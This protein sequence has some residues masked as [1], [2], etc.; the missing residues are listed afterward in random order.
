MKRIIPL[1]ISF[2]F[3]IISV[4]AQSTITFK[5]ENVPVKDGRKVGIRG[6]IYPLSWDSSTPLKKEKDA[7]TVV[8]DFADTED[9]LQFKFV[10]YTSDDD[11][12]WEGIQ[13]RT[14]DLSKNENSV[15]QNIWNKEQIIDISTLKPISSELL[16]KDYELIEKMVLDV[17]PGTFRYNDKD[18]I[19]LVL[20]ELKTKFSQTLTYQEAY[21]AISKVTAKLKCD[22]TKAGFNNQNKLINSIIHYQ[23]DK[24]PFTFK[25]IDNKMI[26]IYNASKNKGLKRGDQIVSINSTPASTILENMLPFVGADGNTDHNRI[27]KLEVNGYDFRYNAFD[28]FYPLLYPINEDLIELEVLGYDQNTIDTIQVEPITR[29]ERFSRLSERYA[30]F[31]RTRDDMWNYEITSD[32]IAKLTLNSFGLNSWKAMTINYKGFLKNAFDDI[33]K[34]N[35]KHLI[36]DIRE[37]TGGNDEMSKELF[38][39]LTKTGIDLDREGKTRYLKF[40]DLLKPHIKTWGANPWYY[41]LKPKDSTPVNGYYIFKENFS[42]KDDVSDYKIYDGHLYLI[43]GAA[44]TSLAFYTALRFKLQKLGWIVGEE[45]GGNLNDINGGQILF[46][47]LPNSKIEIDFPVM[48]AFSTTKQPNT[49]IVPDLKVNY[50]IEDIIEKRDPAFDTILKII[51]K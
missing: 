18:Q 35:I 48:G 51:K 21:L 47:T 8:L 46:L 16:L 27:Y 26:I 10:T 6:N 3:L 2:F 33:N 23:A 12:I 49:G 19:H 11:L 45:T 29:E 34:K 40:P 31:P 5:V 25:W 36:I 28:I 4:P 37:N 41:N 13:N 38:K 7:Y 1:F 14:L 39:Y 30:D 42:L 20:E 15:S 43:T 32:T 22:H 9:E 17:H 24:L 44:N 50:K